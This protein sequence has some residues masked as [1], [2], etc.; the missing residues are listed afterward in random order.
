MIVDAL[1]SLLSV[2]MKF[3]DMYLLVMDKAVWI[4]GCRYGLMDMDGAD[5]E[6]LPYRHFD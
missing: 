6:G 2:D 1:L 3:M 4:C 5:M